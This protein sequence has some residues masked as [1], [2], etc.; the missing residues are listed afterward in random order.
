MRLI[1]PTLLLILWSINGSADHHA[2]ASKISA[3]NLSDI[4]KV[5]ASD[6]FEGRA[7]GTPGEDKTVAYLITQMEKIG[8]TPGGAE[9][10]WTQAVPMMRSEVKPSVKMSFSSADTVLMLAQG[11]SV[12]VDT[13]TARTNIVAADVPVVFVGFGANAP[14]QDWDDYGE[15][16]LTGKLAIFLVND[17][18]FAAEPQEAVSG[19]FGNRRMT[20]YGRWTYKYEIAAKLGAAGVI[21]IHT[22]PSAGYPWQ[23]VETSWTGPQSELP[24]EGEPTIEIKGWMSNTSTAALFA[25]AGQNLDSL[26]QQ[27][28]S[29]NFQPLELPI[30]TDLTLPI[31]MTSNTSANILARIEGGDLADEVIVFTAHH[32][33]LGKGVATKPGEDVIYN[34]ALDNATGVASVLAIG[35]AFSQL[36]SQSRRS[37]LFAFVGAE[38]Q[39]LLGSLYLALHPPV[40]PGKLAAAVNMDGAQ[41]HGRSLDISYVGYGRST[42]DQAAQMA[43]DLQGRVIKGDQDPSKGYFYRSDHFSLA[44]IGVPSLNFEGGEDLRNGGIE[45][46]RAFGEIYTNQHYHQASDEIT[47]EWRF[48]GM[49][50]DAQFGFYTAWSL[51]NQS[52]LPAWYPGDEFEAVRR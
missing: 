6:E 20:Y 3:N 26:R 50:E 27:A 23:V 9:G 42:V 38:E 18:D 11:T 12:S 36:P 37:L 15:I 49:V 1:L 10:S 31:T 34:G 16:D 8:L 51:A 19:R 46:G 45:A 48:D 30:T 7:P 13:A 24:N 2:E 32:D 5:M 21:I 41:I 4:V 44:K 22:D 29:K 28:S 17:P 39:G 25:S 14:E 35:R 47:D 40:A 43:A 33:H 52:A